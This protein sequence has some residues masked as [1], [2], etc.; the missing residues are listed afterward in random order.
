MARDLG[1]CAREFNAGRA[2]A[3]HGEGELGLSSLFLLF[4]LGMLEGEQDAAAD[5]KRVRQHL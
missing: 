5:F 2:R 4:P 3:D 1:K